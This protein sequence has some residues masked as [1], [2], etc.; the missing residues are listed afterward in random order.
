MTSIDDEATGVGRDESPPS[1][2]ASGPVIRKLDSRAL[3]GLAHP[4]RVRIFEQ[5]TYYGPATATQLGERLGESSGS[6]S[7]HLRQLAKFGF[8]EE[9]AERGNQRDR[10]WRRVPGAIQWSESE[11]RDDPAGRAAAEL[12]DSEFEQLS[13]RRR[14]GY[15]DTIHRWPEEWVSAV[16]AHTMH[17]VLTAA[18]AEKMGREL[19]AVFDRYKRRLG[20][21]DLVPAAER[22]ADQ[23]DVDV[24]ITLL[25][26]SEPPA[27]PADPGGVGDPAS[28]PTG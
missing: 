14:Q 22:E 26:V 3:Q 10:W 24:Q 15:W 8:V 12:I 28:R 13:Q 21:R 7:Y 9:D 17:I 2:A 6:T 25:P 11:H 4:L 16:M 19:Q 27:A 18:E 1:E 5:L 23:F 20:A